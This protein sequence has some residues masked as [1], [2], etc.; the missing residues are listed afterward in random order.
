MEIAFTLGW[1]IVPA[2]I[3][4]ACLAYIIFANGYASQA[5]DPVSSLAG[6]VLD[7]LTIKAR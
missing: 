7:L 2:T 5:S 6:G 1:W 3:T 4:L